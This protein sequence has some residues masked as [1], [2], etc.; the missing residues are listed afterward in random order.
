MGGWV[1]CC[2]GAGV[3]YA[4]QGGGALR[5]ELLGSMMHSNGRRAGEYGRQRWQARGGVWWAAVA[6]ERNCRAEHC[7]W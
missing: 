3:A 4:H 1:R 5:E 2:A 7:W 6:G